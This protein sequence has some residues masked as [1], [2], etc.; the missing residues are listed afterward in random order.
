M[1]IISKIKTPIGTY[2]EDL[3]GQKFGRLTVLHID[4]RI[5][6]GQH[7]Y[8]TWLCKCDCGNIISVLPG[9]LKK[10][11]IQ[12]C[13]CLKKETSTKNGKNR[14]KDITNQRFG[15]LLALYPTEKRCGN[16][17]VWHCVCDCGKE[18]NV[19]IQNLRNGNTKS[20]GCYA[21]ELMIKKGRESAKDIFGMKFGKLTCIR[22]TEKRKLRC[23]IWECKCDCG[24]TCYVD[25]GSLK[26][27]NTVSCGCETSKGEQ[28]I[29]SLL[30]KMNIL[31]ITQKTFPKCVNDKTNRKLKFDF[32]LP[33]YNICIEYDGKQHFEETSMC[34][35]TLEERKNRD[36]IKNK[37]CKENNIG[38]IR[39]PY[40]DFNKIDDSYLIDKINEVL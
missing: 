23:I 30:Q 21:K 11:N 9:N 24:N 38:L 16:S 27:G 18:C 33:D 34:E 15:R 29:H 17:V 13:G 8:W 6:L 32:Y 14:K 37:F 36:K 5:K 22:P 40:W 39:I 3:T 28:K 2:I 12:S 1:R 10:K 25:I 19:S 31:F 4:K 7:L 20:C 35:D 26:S